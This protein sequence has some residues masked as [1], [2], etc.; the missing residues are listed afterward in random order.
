MR[1]CVLASV[2]VGLLALHVGAQDAVEIKIAHPKAGDRLKVTKT[3]KTTGKLMIDIGG[4]KENK[5]IKENSTVVYIDDVITPGKNDE[6]P[7][8]QTRTY[9]KYDAEKDGMKED[10]PP[11]NTPILIEKKEDKYEFSV[12]GEKLK[13]EFA[14]KLDREF[15]K[16]ELELKTEILLP[17]KAVKPGDTWKIDGAKLAKSLNE[18][19]ELTVDG[20]KTVATG[21]LVKAYKKGNQQYGVMEFTIEA[22]VKGLGE[23][24]K[25]KAGSAMTFKLTVD[26]NIDGTD[27]SEQMNGTFK[28]KIDAEGMG[29]SVVITAD[30]TVSENKQLLPKGKK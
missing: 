2:F 28:L 11:L 8:K 3:E 13:G 17:G 27:P 6:K 18:D 30:G 1:K 23:G 4:K 22:P 25:V 14:K 26:G 19:G 29:A 9:E 7:L 10:G 12:K 20:D 16:P 5:D 24:A 15:N 21:K